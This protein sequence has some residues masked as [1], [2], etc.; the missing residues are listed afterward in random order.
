MFSFDDNPALH[1]DERQPPHSPREVLR[2]TSRHHLEELKDTLHH[3][4]GYLPNAMRHLVESLESPSV[5]DPV[6]AVVL[7][8]PHL[9]LDPQHRVA[10]LD[11]LTKFSH[12][13]LV[14]SFAIQT[15]AQPP[16][17]NHPDV[18]RAASDA[19]LS[20]SEHLTP[21]NIKTIA[22]LATIQRDRSESL[23]S[24]SARHI[25]EA[26]PSS[27]IP[28]ESLQTLARDWYISRRGEPN[29]WLASISH[30]PSLQRV[31]ILREILSGNVP[32]EGKPS[33]LQRM[34][35]FPTDLHHAA[36]GSGFVA[37]IFNKALP[38]LGVGRGVSSLRAFL[39]AS[40]IVYGVKTL[41]NATS[42][43]AA[44][45]QREPERLEAVRHL[46]TIYERAFE[47]CDRNDRAAG[48][49]AY[50][51]LRRASRSLLQEPIVRAAA[52][53]ALEDIERSESS[54]LL[55]QRFSP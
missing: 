42:M 15:L 29:P 48:R 41:A 39:I 11:S 18:V 45:A 37:I 20:A 50:L 53:A 44:N 33:L 46:K 43:D 19:I 30:V 3:T 34:S 25:L 49:S 35:T 36:V 28:H 52:R 12:E 32:Y 27:A 10:L 16:Y 23:A 47:S 24:A 5:R 55:Y 51:T 7:S 40:T 13:P 21:T 26:L 22:N 54:F 14:Q 8:E 17:Q 1:I 31:A 9:F 4:S 2:A 6:I 38:L